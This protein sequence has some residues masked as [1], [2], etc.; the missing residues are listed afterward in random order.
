METGVTDMFSGLTTSAITTTATSW[1]T[2]FD[3]IL[4]VVIGIGIAFACVR[5]VKSLFF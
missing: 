2:N 3:S 5:F 4:L 1:T